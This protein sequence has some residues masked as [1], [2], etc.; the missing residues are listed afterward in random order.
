[1]KKVSFL[2]VFALV[3]GMVASLSAQDG[4]TLTPI[5]TIDNGGFDEGAAEISAF[6]AG[7]QR[8]FVTNGETDS[9]DIF[10][11]SDATAPTLVSSIDI[12]EFGGGV[13]SVAVF[14]GL[15]A[16]AVEADPATDPGFVVFF[17]TDGNSLGSVQVGALP[18]MVT[19][20]P[21]GTLV[22]T[23][24]EGEPNDDY[25]IDPLGS[26]SIIDVSGGVDMATATILTF[27]GVEIP[28]EV[29]V[30]GPGASAAQ[31]LEPE[32]V[33]VSPDGSTAFVALQEN[34]ALAIVDVESAS[35]TAVVSLGFKDHS[36][37]GN[38]LDAGTD[39]GV[40]NITNWPLLGMYQPDGIATYEVDGEVYIV[41]A[42]EGDTRDYDGY[43]EEGEI[44]ESD[45]EAESVDI[46]TLATED[47]ILGL[48]IT[49]ANGDTD[50]DGDIDVLYIP[51]ARS[52]SIWA[53]DGTLVYDSGA[54]FEQI[55][56]ELLPDDFNSTNDENGDFDGRSD[57]KGPEPEAVEIGVI[58]GVPYAFI[59]LERVGGIMVYNIADPT[60]PE[61]VTYVNTRD[62][63]GNAEEGTAGDLAPEDA[64]FVPA[65]QSPTGTNIL[66]VTYEVSGS[67]T[68]FE[69]E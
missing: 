36:L 13:N 53:A 46:E 33:A 7:S 62:F 18:D 41:T 31:D 44:G 1:M 35:I 59:V 6:D 48:G 47:A 30:F 26:V 32:Y 40:I 28:E 17:D 38:E 19:F 4:L 10:D 61:Y 56:A 12:T 42:N 37:E 55:T 34:N 50:G 23:A 24:D 22:F 58:D 54:D 43:S 57:N 51:G 20:S 60:A 16:A 11:L 67:T 25:T 8:L 5:S 9:V 68:I 21:D 52:F 64:V 15:L 65:D 29:R 2:L 45:I 3:F 69:I 66:I 63:S 49:E 39:D 27:E 14:D